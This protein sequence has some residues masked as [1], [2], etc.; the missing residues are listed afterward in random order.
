[1]VI[2][3][4]GTMSRISNWGEMTDAE[5]ESTLK[6]IGRRNQSRLKALG[7]EEGMEGGEAGN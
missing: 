6:L 4:D 3:V 7:R 1:M 2:G 5:K